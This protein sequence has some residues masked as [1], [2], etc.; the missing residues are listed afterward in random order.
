[1]ARYSEALLGHRQ[2]FVWC[3]VR[4]MIWEGVFIDASLTCND[5]W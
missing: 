2:I 1:M 5:P 4:Y 3:M